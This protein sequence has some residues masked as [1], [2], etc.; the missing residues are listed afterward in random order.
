M[1]PGRNPKTFIDEEVKKDSEGSSRH[2]ILKTLKWVTIIYKAAIMLCLSLPKLWVINS[3]WSINSS[4]NGL[5][6]IIIINVCDCGT[7]QYQWGVIT[8]TV[9]SEL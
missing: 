6:V 9:K 7:H 4:P 3:G 8:V 5:M 2:V 1:E